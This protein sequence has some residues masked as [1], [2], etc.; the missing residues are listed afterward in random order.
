MRVQIWISSR[1]PLWT[2][3]CL[4][5]TEPDTWSEVERDTA[6]TRA[7][8]FVGAVRAILASTALQEV[9]AAEQTVVMPNCATE[10][11]NTPANALQWFFTEIV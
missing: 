2:A 7:D 11:D 5:A 6:G 8:E 10:L 1:A 4:L 3:V 9:S